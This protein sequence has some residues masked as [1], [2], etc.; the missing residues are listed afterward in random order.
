M[1][2]VLTEGDRTVTRWTI[3]EP[4]EIDF[5]GVV[6]LK[7]NIVAGTISILSSDEA[8][9]LEV[10]EISGQPLEIIHE[11]GML[12]V[13]QKGSGWDG[14]LKWLQNTRGRVAVTVT[15]P[16]ECPVNLNL[17]TANAVVTGLSGRVTVK[18]ASG[19]VTLDGVTGA[20]DANTATGDVEAQGLGGS[21]SFSSLSGDL[22]LAGGTVD[23]L[24]AHSV[25]GDIT[26]DVNLRDGGRGQV[27]TVSGEVTIRLPESIS[28]TV[29]LTSVSGRV[30]AAFPGLTRQD[31]TMGKTVTGTLGDGDASLS[32][33]SVSGAITL[34]SRPD[35]EELQEGEG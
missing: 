32:V 26:T 34:L 18:S 9:R 16:R 7:A 27:N 12:T 15:V 14:V 3:E 23:R 19:D 33:N 5:N 10:G 35:P 31:R 21:V 30:D 22:A 17:M 29:N 6:A 4:K 24:V 1:K 11:A 13:S 25:N 8:P 28:A 20:I 2:S